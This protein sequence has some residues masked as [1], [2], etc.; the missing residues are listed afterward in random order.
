MDHIDSNAKQESLEFANVLNSIE[1]VLPNE[2]LTSKL[3]CWEKNE[4][5]FLTIVEETLS[6]YSLLGDK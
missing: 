3:K 6:Q 5:S 4:K 2:E 1:G